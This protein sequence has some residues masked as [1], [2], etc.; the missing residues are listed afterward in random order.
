ML[1]IGFA[2][3]FLLQPPC[4]FRHVEANIIDLEVARWR[5]RHRAVMRGED[6]A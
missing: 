3:G 5:R 2:V 4:P 6:P 1:V